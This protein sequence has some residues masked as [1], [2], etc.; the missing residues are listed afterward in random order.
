MNHL[1]KIDLQFTQ[2]SIPRR[3]RTCI[4]YFPNIFALLIFSRKVWQNKMVIASIGLTPG[5]ILQIIEWKTIAYQEKFSMVEIFFQI[6][7]S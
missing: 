1:N 3:S 5:V 4:M 2:C 7:L 6:T